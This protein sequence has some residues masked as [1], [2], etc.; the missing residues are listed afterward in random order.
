MKKVDWKHIIV[1]IGE[2]ADICR[3]KIA[4]S[5]DMEALYK[6]GKIA[7]GLY[8]QYGWYNSCRDNCM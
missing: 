7:L 8:E 3:R 6:H 1:I 5:G 4:K 2:F